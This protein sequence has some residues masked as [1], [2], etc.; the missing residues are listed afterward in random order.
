MAGGGDAKRFVV[1]PHSLNYLHLSEGPGMFI[2]IVPCDGQ[3]F[4]FVGK[5]RK[6]GLKGLKKIGFRLYNSHTTYRKER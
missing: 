6:N 3:N 5:S 2:M 1:E 4:G